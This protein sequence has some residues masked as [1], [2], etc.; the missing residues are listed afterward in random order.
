MTTSPRTRKPLTLPHPCPSCFSLVRFTHPAGVLGFIIA[1]IAI[2]WSLIVVETELH[3]KGHCMVIFWL[4]L[5]ILLNVLIGLTPYVDNF[6]HLG[7]MT[8]GFLFGV[9]HMQRISFRSFFGLE[10][11]CF[12]VFISL[13][14]RFWGAIFCFFLLVSSTA[15]LFLPIG[16]DFSCSS[17]R[18]LSCVPFPPWTEAKYWFCDDCDAHAQGEAAYDE[19]RGYFEIT[20]TCPNGDIVVVHPTNPTHDL[21]KVSKSLPNLCRKNCPSAFAT[22]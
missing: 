17:C 9:A 15:L 21:K 19:Q 16:N 14:I 6:C 20:V 8:L 1:D 5:D 22:N 13:L 11:P 12:G 7:G 4:I 2:N 18:Y 3:H 10:R